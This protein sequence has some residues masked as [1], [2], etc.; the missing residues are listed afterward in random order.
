MATIM[1]LFRILTTL[2]LRWITITRK[3]NCSSMLGE[4]MLNLYPLLC[5]KF[6]NMQE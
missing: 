4:I 5:V 3:Q 1:S 2:L 6:A